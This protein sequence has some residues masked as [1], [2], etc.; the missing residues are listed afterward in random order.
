MSQ[1]H[2]HFRAGD[3]PPAERRTRR[4]LHES[5]CFDAATNETIAVSGG[6]SVVV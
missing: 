4:P 2:V 3:H 5:A 6:G 1:N